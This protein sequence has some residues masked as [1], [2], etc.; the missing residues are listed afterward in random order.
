[1]KK[2]LFIAYYFPPIG[3][4]GVQRSLKFVKY[5]PQF[6]F[7]PLVL[8]ASAPP[9]ERWSP[10]D[11]RL[12]A[13]LPPECSVHRV[14]GLPAVELNGWNRRVR[15]LCMVP[16]PFG[17]AW[18]RA[19]VRE[20]ERLCREQRPDLIFVT[21]SPFEGATAAA[22]LS[23]RFG[24]PWV[25]DLRD[26]WALDEMQVFA[27]G[28][29]RRLAR[30]R[31]RAALQS[32]SLVIMNTP[33]ASHRL[34]TAFPEYARRPVADLTNGYDAEDF[35]T[36]SYRREE[37]TF[38]IVHTGSLHTKQGQIVARQRALLER[39]GRIEPGVD[40]LSRSHAYL[41][42]ALRRWQARDAS[43]MRH[44]RLIL[45]GSLTAEDQRL[46]DQSPVRHL[47]TTEGYRSHAQ[48][49]QLQKQAELLFLPMHNLPLGRRATVVPGKTYEYLATERPILAAVPEGDARDFVRQA[50]TGRLCA[51][52][53][54]EGMIGILQQRYQQWRADRSP[55]P[56]DRAFIAQFERRSLTARLAEHLREV[57]DRP[58][59]PD[60]RPSSPASPRSRPLSV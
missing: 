18:S 4:G 34:V 1:M 32:A 42:E 11:E 9:A 20:G 16:T 58:Q 56:A 51:P 3:G 52:S 14:S 24:I 50:G 25:A 17:V 41:L 43:V 10:R 59:A 45:A 7:A 2:V 28:L 38:S 54:V 48:T 39:L 46:V 8:T 23:R 22:A 57:L 27:S 47:V 26:P 60:R 19:V 40:F 35:A 55:P 12:L 37:A 30:N 21:L 13:D 6:G 44:V 31:M 29:H 5:L 33:E 53:D 15:E 49:L 36:L